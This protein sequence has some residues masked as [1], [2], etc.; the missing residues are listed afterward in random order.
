MQITRQNAGTL[1]NRALM[2]KEHCSE[3]GCADHP[4]ELYPAGRRVHRP[5]AIERRTMSLAVAVPCALGAALA[6]GTSTAV[7]H[8]VAHG[9]SGAADGKVDASGLLRLVT[10]PRWLLG[11]AA[12]A[13]GLGMHIVA[14]AT[15]PVVLIQPLLVLALPVSLPVARLLGGPPPR[16]SQ[17]LGCV[18]ILAGLTAFFAIVGKSDDADLLSTTSALIA[19][20]I[21]VVVGIAALGLVSTRGRAVKSAVYGGVAGAWFGLVAVLMDGAAASWHAHG[22]QVFLHAEGLVPL[23]ALVVL[24]IASTALTNAAFQIG[25][26]AASWPANAAADPVLAVFLGAV[27]LGERLPHSPWAFL[28]YALCLGAIVYGAVRLA[29]EPAVRAAVE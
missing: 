6:Y 20:G 25:D 7:Q 8:S 4:I 22:F 5:D 9:E 17:Y 18:W 19:I 21:S 13:G 11:T 14:L 28:A 2:P 29:S 27:L 3:E 12:D 1:Q 26:L 24:G 23:I 16:R 10:N 15:G